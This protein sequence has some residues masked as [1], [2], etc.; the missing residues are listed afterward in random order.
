MQDAEL[1]S[2]FKAR[3]E[4]AIAI[5]REKYGALMFGVAKNILKNNEDAEECVSDALLSVWQSIPPNSPK[6]LRAYAA[7]ITKHIALD[8]HRMRT[9]KKRGPVIFEPLDELNECIP[10]AASVENSIEGAELSAAISRWLKGLEPEK[11]ALFVR[12]YWYG[13]TLEE[14]SAKLGV[15]PRRLSKRLCTLRAGLKKYLENEGEYL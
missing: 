5:T 3:D 8:E 11:R 14:L 1:I 2:L 15:H 13:D 9:A 7:S 6:S 4:R 12:R 10:S